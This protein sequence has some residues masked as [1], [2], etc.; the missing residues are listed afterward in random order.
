MQKTILWVDDWFKERHWRDDFNYFF[1]KAGYIMVYHD[2]GR[3]AIE[4]IK[5]GLQFDLGIVDLKLGGMDGYQVIVASKEIHPEIPWFIFS[6]F[7]FPLSDRGI[8]K[9]QRPSYLLEIVND[10]FK[11]REIR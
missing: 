10:F 5:N 4:E 7:P 3:E 6:A 8:E 1:E 2:S 9:P 11:Q